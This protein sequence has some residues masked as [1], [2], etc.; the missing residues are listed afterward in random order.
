METIHRKKTNFIE[1]KDNSPIADFSADTTIV[2]IHDTINFTDLSANNPTSW[3]WD[4]GDGN[5][6]NIQHPSYFYNIVGD[7]SV[8]LKVTNKYGTDSKNKTN[9]ISVVDKSPIADFK[10]DT[11]IV[12]INKIV[13]FSDLSTNN[14]SSWNWNFGDGQSSTQKKPISYFYKYRCLHNYPDC[15]ELLWLQSRN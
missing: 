3:E 2:G 8:K 7:Y 12:G 9:F 13:Y 4:F 6:S 11:T 15:Y 10:A 14:P 1:V 5:T